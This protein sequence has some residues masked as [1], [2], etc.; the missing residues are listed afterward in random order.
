MRKMHVLLYL[1]FLC[2]EYVS[3]NVCTSLSATQLHSLNETI[4]HHDIL[5]YRTHRPE[6]SDAEYDALVEQRNQLSQCM[7]QT[8]DN[9]LKHTATTATT[10]AVQ[11]NARLSSL[12]KGS[13]R[14]E[15]IQFIDAIQRLGSL[16]IL[17]PKIDGVAAEL[18]YKNG[19]LVRASTRGDGERGE[20]ILPA[21]CAIQRIPKHLDT[22]IPLVILHGEIFARLDLVTDQLKPYVSARHFSAATLHTETP[23]KNNLAVLDFFPWQ[24]VNHTFAQDSLSYQQ[25]VNWRFFPVNVYS[26]QLTDSNEAENLRTKLL[27][28]QPSMP[29]L[30]DGIVIKANDMAVRKKLGNNATVPHWAIAWK[31]PASQAV[32]VVNKITFS[33]GRTGK[34]TALLSLEPTILKGV[35]VQQV[36]VGSV[37]QFE[38]LDIALGDL[39]SIAL[40]GDA[41]PTLTKVIKRQTDRQ[42]VNMPD[43]SRYSPISC[44][45]YSQSCS[46]QF[47]SRMKWLSGSQGLDITAINAQILQRLIENGA[48]KELADLLQITPN[49]LKQ[50]G[51]IKHSDAKRIYQSITV[52]RHRTSFQQQIL[53]LSIPNI[54][55]QR[56][57]ELAKHFND[58]SNLIEAST[59]TIMHKTTLGHQQAT[60]LRQ[61]MTIKEV[62][63]VID[64]LKE[65]TISDEEKP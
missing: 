9:A 12:Q 50:Y 40:K 35:M 19:T 51:A 27:E 13:D 55:K 3:A 24:W 14:K 32:T 41:I 18:V 34:I 56:S 31:F 52:A 45:R 60:T 48:I 25:L 8:T 63:K 4:Q 21:I 54:G 11:H 15:I 47:L 49:T 36:S 58:W 22:T 62:A 33:I 44:L 64:L 39:I 20:D 38:T 30:M 42:P 65:N 10:A 43:T 5:Y 23:D 59:E 26:Y 29:F 61:Y 53:A 37:K 7:K 57:S 2:I 17:Q 46:Q 28:S 6:L 16:V 1:L